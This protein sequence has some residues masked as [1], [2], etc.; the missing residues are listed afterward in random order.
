MSLELQHS[1]ED[2]LGSFCNCLVE[3]DPEQRT[4]E[5]RVRRRA[6][7]ISSA[8]QSAVLAALMLIPLFGKTE[9]IALV[10]M[11][12]IPPYYH[13]GGQVHE[14]AATPQRRPTT[15]YRIW[16]PPRIPNH[17]STVENG[18]SQPA[19]SME[20]IGLLDIGPD[21]P[22]CIN[23]P[24]PE[25]PRPPQPQAETQTSRK[26]L[27]M[28]QLDPAM[29][30]HRVEP[31]YPTLPRQMGRSGRVEL[32]AIISTGGSIQSL[33]VVSGDPLFFQ[34]ALQAVQQWRYKPTILN[35]Q[36]VEIDTF[37]TVIYNIKR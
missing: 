27:Q 37:I 20:P 8:L 17:I 30:V 28:T 23:M 22:G 13:H 31:F 21:C 9:R 26:R 34:S 3:G 33:Q 7:A 10:G 19:E 6:L 36:P 5:R 18:P 24:G 2:T 14:D 1:P 4:R 35:G 16:A 15:I 29:L 12:A 32:R 25:G 11:I